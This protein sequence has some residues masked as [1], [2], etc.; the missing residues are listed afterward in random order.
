MIVIVFC[1]E[2]VSEDGL[3]AM[4]DRREILLKSLFFIIWTAFI[5]LFFVDAAAVQV[6]V[7][8]RVCVRVLLQ[9]TPGRLCVSVHGNAGEVVPD[10]LVNC[11]KKREVANDC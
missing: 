11:G 3:M 10:D 8:V 7:C 6:Y 5:S 2:S 1:S 9:K 4:M